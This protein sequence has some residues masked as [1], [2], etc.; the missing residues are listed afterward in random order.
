[1]YFIPDFDETS[2]YYEAAAGVSIHPLKMESPL[3]EPPVVGILG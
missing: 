1:M 3:I 2:G